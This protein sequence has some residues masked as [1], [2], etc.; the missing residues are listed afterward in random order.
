MQMQ[1]AA[2]KNGKRPHG[3]KGIFTEIFKDQD[4]H[5]YCTFH[6][7]VMEKGEIHA[8]EEDILS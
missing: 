2:L 8:K 6:F 1:N 3:E 7:G 5:S 4:I